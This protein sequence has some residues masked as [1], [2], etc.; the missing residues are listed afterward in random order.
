MRSQTER[1]SLLHTQRMAARVLV[2]DDSLVMA[3]LIT[4]ALTGAGLTADAVSN[5]AALD[6]QLERNAYALVLVDVNMP[7][8]YGDDVVEFLKVQRKLTAKLFLYSDIP[9]AELEAKAKAVGADGFITKARGLDAA[10]EAIRAAVEGAGVRKRRVLLVDD[11]EP[12]TRLVSAEL[13]AQ[14]HEVVS[15][16]SIDAATKIILKKKT[17]PDLVLL[18]P[19]TPGLNSEELCRLIKSNSL[20]AGIRVLFCSAE[21][22]SKL[23]ERAK[24]AG[25]DGSLRKESLT[26]RALLDLL[27]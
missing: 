10:V 26:A 5:L 20:F 24:A 9:E 23:D 2:V 12:T 18:D 21:E 7:E 13:T 25:A 16:S 17:R 4:Q 3:Q 15:A 14:G 22:E 8:M 19:R 1:K 6:Q 27:R 11:G